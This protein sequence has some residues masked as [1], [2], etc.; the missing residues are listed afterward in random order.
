MMAARALEILID[1]NKQRR[2]GAR[3]RAEAI[4]EFNTEKIIPQYEALYERVVRA[5]H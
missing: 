5:A 4:A 3:G 2:M 1:E